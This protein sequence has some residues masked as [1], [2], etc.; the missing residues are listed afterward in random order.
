[1]S[2][3]IPSDEIIARVMRRNHIADLVENLNELIWNPRAPASAPPQPHNTRTSFSSSTLGPVCGNVSTPSALSFLSR[4][5]S[6]SESLE[7]VAS[8]S[9]DMA[10]ASPTMSASPFLCKGFSVASESR[11]SANSSFGSASVESFKPSTL[12]ADVLKKA[13]TMQSSKPRVSADFVNECVDAVRAN[14]TP[15]EK[16]SL[17]A[18]G[19]KVTIDSKRLQ[20]RRKRYADLK[21]TAVVDVLPCVVTHKINVLDAARVKPQRKAARSIYI[22]KPP[23]QSMSAAYKAKRAPPSAEK[24]GPPQHRNAHPS[25]CSRPL[26]KPESCPKSRGAAATPMRS[27]IIFENA[28]AVSFSVN[29]LTEPRCVDADCAD[30][31]NSCVSRFSLGDD[32][33]Y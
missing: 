21:H 31:S 6:A 7:N 20:E 33:N 19:F 23:R 9:P 28:P 11:S 24:H 17:E 3:A 15:V 27:I 14:L 13:D 26:F 29:S 10:F 8:S 5:V 30:D 2:A 1:M 25:R 16:A 18:S 32:R 4:S 22:S 12:Q